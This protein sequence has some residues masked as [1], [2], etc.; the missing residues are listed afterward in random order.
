M[1]IVT[2][3]VLAAAVA[4]TL[5][6]AAQTANPH[7]GHGAHAAPAAQGGNVMYEGEVKR[8]NAEAKRITLAH[9]PLKEFDMPPMTMAFAVKDPKQIA[10][11]KPGDKVRFKLESAGDNMVITRI[12]PAK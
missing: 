4:L 6:A 9:G 5:P 11:L 7:A 10:A 3:L 8:V 2:S 1:K 12:E